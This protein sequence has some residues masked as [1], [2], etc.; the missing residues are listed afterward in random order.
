LAGVPDQAKQCFGQNAGQPGGS[1]EILAIGWLQETF[2][3]KFQAGIFLAQ[4]NPAQF[5]RCD[6]VGETGSDECAGADSHIGIQLMQ[7]QA[8]N[9]FIDCP[10]PGVL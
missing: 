4:E 10:Q 1:L 9:A 6:T 8:V 2:G 7:F 5:F 3:L